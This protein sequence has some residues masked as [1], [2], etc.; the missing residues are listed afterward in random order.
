MDH[1]T[2]LEGGPGFLYQARFFF[3]HANRA[4][5]FFFSQSKARIF[6]LNIIHVI[7]AEDEARIFFLATVT[8]TQGKRV[9]FYFRM[10]SLPV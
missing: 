8:C 9:Y 1:S 4:R 2:F 7:L 5:I 6:F 10:S 3:Y